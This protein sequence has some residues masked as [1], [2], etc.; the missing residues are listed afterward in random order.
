[1]EPVARLRAKG[2]LGGTFDPPHWAH[3]A[4][5]EHAREALGLD[6]VIFMPAGVPPHKGDRAISLPEHRVAMVE[7]A[8]A[9]NPHFRISRMEVER[10]G[11]SYTADTMQVYAECA[12]T[13]GR[14]EPVFILS[15][16]ALCGLDTWHD[17]FRLLDQCRIAVVPRH[18]YRHPS[19]AWLEERFPARQDRFVFLD[20]P[21]LGNSASE[22]RRR[23]S[24]GL[25]IRYLLP[26]S[27]EAY[28]HERRLYPSEL[29]TSNPMPGNL[30][31]EAQTT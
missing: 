22:I 7:L 17:P 30:T 21:D 8:I 23:A 6:G 20:G 25:S 5:A 28:V 14:P 12:R 29:W 31:V 10:P 16:D 11:P 15:V 19:R 13:E 2:V 1:M 18:G 3:L 4:I 9:G 27:V 24:A 26:R